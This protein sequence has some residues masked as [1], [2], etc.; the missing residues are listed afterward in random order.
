MAGYSRP[1]SPVDL[2]D[3]GTA[4]AERKE[5]ESTDTAE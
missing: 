5:E 4:T 2:Y 3:S 1:S